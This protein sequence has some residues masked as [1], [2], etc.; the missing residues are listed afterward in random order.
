VPIFAICL[1]VIPLAVYVLTYI[2]YFSLGHSFADLI[3]LQEQ[4]YGYHANLEATHP[5]S[6]PWYGWLFGYRAVFLY[7][8]GEGAE[9]S[10]IWTIPNLVVFWGGLLGI[11]AM[12]RESR[13]VRSAA[14]GVVMLAAVIQV[15]PWT[16]VGRVLFLYHY[17]PVVPFLAIAL[18]WWMTIG[19]RESRYRTQIAA[20][21]AVASVL[22]FVAVL[23]MLEGWSMSV[24]YLDAVRNAL[25]WVIP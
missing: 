20:G 19:L 21:V 18:A 14:L 11:V 10:E 13:V 5:F 8:A 23:P 12:V 4:M 1:G 7:L 15:L 17:L 9:R 24:G 6:S 2:P 22:F 16:T 25:P 3:G